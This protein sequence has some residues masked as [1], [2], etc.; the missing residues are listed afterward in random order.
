MARIVTVLLALSAAS[1]P[2]SAFATQRIAVLDVK[3]DGGAAPTIGRQLT[4]RLAQEIGARPNVSVIAPDDIRAM[5]EQHTQK[6]LLGCA[7]DSCLAEI[8]GALGVDL[9]V[10]GRVSKIGEAYGVSLSAVDPAEA[11][12]VG[13]VTETYRGESIALLELVGPMVAQL[14]SKAPLTGTLSIVGAVDGSRI[15]IDD[16]VRGT[17]PAGQMAG[18]SIGARR[19]QIVADGY[20]PFEQHVIVR[21]GIETTLAV[22]QVELPSTP[23]YATWWFWTATAVAVGGGATAAIL[24]GGGGDTPGG[25]PAGATG[26]GIGINAD[27]AL[28]GGR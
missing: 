27:D 3:V 14:L 11:R 16:A 8:G 7:E 5:L 19:V 9:L 20:A 21:N 23:F 28:F 24:L 15:L 25:T 13:H 6:Q 26:V 2:S 22:A 17:A 10:S 1:V 18:V 4:A 12:A